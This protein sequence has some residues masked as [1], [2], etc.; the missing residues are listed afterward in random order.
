MLY[1]YNY[2]CFSIDT[3]TISSLLDVS[4]GQNKKNTWRMREKSKLLKLLLSSYRKTNVTFSNHSKR[5]NV[6]VNE[7]L[8]FYTLGFITLKFTLFIT[9][10]FG[11]GLKLKNVIHFLK[12]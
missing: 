10:D 12:V 3:K 9:K 6:C 1:I 5:K 8:V 11:K 7:I 4:H 2:Y